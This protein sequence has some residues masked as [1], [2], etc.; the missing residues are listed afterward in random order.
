MLANS[1]KPKKLGPMLAL[2]ALATGA[3]A[4][5]SRPAHA[6]STTEC[7][8]Q[9]VEYYKDTLLIQCVGGTNF[10]A[11]VAPL[12]TSSTVSCQGFAQNLDTIKIWLSMAQTAL[13]A[14]KNVLM[15]YTSCGPYN[16]GAG[17]PLV[18]VLDLEK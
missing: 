9:K 4:V 5:T 8:V 17:I 13:L 6:T 7:K 12:N 2:C 16:S 18:T 3:M 1:K 11:Q 14:G 15:Y 10:F